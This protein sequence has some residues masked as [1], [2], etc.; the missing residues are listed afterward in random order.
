MST[1]TI[2][3][4][5]AKSL[6]SVCTADATGHVLRRQDWGR[7]VFMLW[8]AQVPASTV[9]AMEACRGAHH[10]ASNPRAD[11]DPA[12]GVP[13]AVRQWPSPTNMR[14]NGGPYWPMRKPTTP[15]QGYSIPE[16][17]APGRPTRRTSSRHSLDLRGP[18]SPLP[19]QR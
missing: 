16:A 12:A 3:V 8:L 13:D 1:I 2:G 15:K 17:P 11:L 4:D 6:F 14:G 9:V 7:E 10:W 5:L 18:Y 19:R